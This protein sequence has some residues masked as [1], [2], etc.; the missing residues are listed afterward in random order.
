M[1]VLA[2]ISVVFIS[3]IILLSSTGILL[4][5]H[6]CNM[7]NSD[8]WNLFSSINCNKYTYEP[9]CCLGTE[10]KIEKQCCSNDGHFYKLGTYN[11]IFDSF[12]LGIYST[13]LI[14]SDCVYLEKIYPTAFHI[15]DNIPPP[16]LPNQIF[17]INNSF[18]I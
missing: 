8:E 13:D 5:H 16:N 9:E 11:S 12:I 7:C 14:L 10:V 1:K 3:L 2:K 18:R 17:L 4:V 15:F 6:H